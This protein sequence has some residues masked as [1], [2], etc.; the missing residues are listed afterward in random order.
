MGQFRFLVAELDP[1]TCGE[2]SK[3]C[4]LGVCAELA[5][6]DLYVKLGAACRQNKKH[7]GLAGVVDWWRC[8]KRLKGEK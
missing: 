4:A 3:P 8:P 5:V 7:S 2:E 1:H 6:S